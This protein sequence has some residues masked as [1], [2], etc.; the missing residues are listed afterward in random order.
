MIDPGQAATVSSVH[1]PVRICSGAC[2]FF[3]PV[4]DLGRKVAGTG[5]CEKHGSGTAVRV[6]NMCLWTK[7]PKAELVEM[8]VARS[9]NLTN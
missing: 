1:A 5:A 7:S 9:S 4:Y 6:G 2:P 3:E 8:M